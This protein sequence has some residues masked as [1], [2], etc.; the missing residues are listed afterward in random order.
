MK[1][2]RKWTAWL[3]AGAVILTI[4]A[5]CADKNDNAVP[6]ATENVA[7]AAAN[8]TENMADAAGNTA[9][10]MTDAAGNTMDAAGNATENMASAAGNTMDAAGNTVMNAA[11]TTADATSNVV[12]G[13]GNAMANAG[14]A[15]TYTPKI[16]AALGVNAAM[17][18]SNINVDTIGAK[19]TIV[20]RGTVTSAA[21]MKLAESIA[22][23]NGPKDFTVTNQLKMAGK[24]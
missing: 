22:K 13:A 21:Q 17:K 3:G 6:D 2:Y 23:T 12:T 9:E 16:K 1:N 11:D 10:N 24:M 7:V 8:T 15:M 19:K 4:G 14:D 18:G 20:L 5:G